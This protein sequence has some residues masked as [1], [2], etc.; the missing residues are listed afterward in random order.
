[1]TLGIVD[2]GI[3]SS[4]EAN[5]IFLETWEIYDSYCGGVTL[6]RR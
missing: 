3:V 2:Y 4:F 6:V 1:M 5:S